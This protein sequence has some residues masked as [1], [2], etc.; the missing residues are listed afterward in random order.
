M[1]LECT[2]CTVKC[3][4]ECTL[5]CAECTVK[6]MMECTLEFIL[7]FTEWTLECT[8]CTVKYRL[9]CTQSTFGFLSYLFEFLHCFFEF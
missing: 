4:L 3:M 2:E 5:E 6:C 9:E 1:S 8:E 7:E